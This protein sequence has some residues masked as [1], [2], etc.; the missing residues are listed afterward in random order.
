MCNQ[1]LYSFSLFLSRAVHESCVQIVLAQ[2]NRDAAVLTLLEKLSEV[3][4]FMT[5]DE[6]LGQI[7][8]MRDILGNISQQNRECAHLELFG[9]L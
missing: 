3:Y 2:A 4:S 9:D 7:S 5:Q 6:I 1:S 8:S